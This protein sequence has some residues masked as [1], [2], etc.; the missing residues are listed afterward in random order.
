[1]K[2]ETEFLRVRK[3]NVAVDLTLAG[4]APRQVELFL[5][6]PVRPEDR[7]NQVLDLLEKGMPFLPARDL[8][9]ARWEIFSRDAVLWVRIP[10]ADLSTGDETDELFDIR[11]KVCVDLR[12]SERLQG[13]L[14]WSAEERSTRVTDYMNS[15]G[16]FFRLWQEEHVFLVNKSYVLRVIEDP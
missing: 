7:R 2:G 4:T 13:E 6:D 8:G 12:S 3:Q 9:S 5:A 15:E 1:M 11:Q 10:L 16:R 14:L